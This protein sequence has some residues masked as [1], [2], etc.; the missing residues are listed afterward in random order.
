MEKIHARQEQAEIKEEKT[1]SQKITG[2]FE[3]LQ[4]KDVTLMANNLV[5]PDGFAK[6]LITGIILSGEELNIKVDS[7]F[8]KSHRKYYQSSQKFTGGENN[9]LSFTIGK[10]QRLYAGS[11]SIQEKHRPF[12]RGLGFTLPA[13]KLLSKTNVQ[14]GWGILSTKEAIEKLRDTPKFEPQFSKYEE[15]EKLSYEDYQKINWYPP[16]KDFLT[17][18]HLAR[19]AGM[20]DGGDQAEV[21]MNMM[22]N[23]FPRLRLEEVVILIPEKSRESI[24]RYLGKKLK[25]CEQ[26]S[27]K[28]KEAF[29]V[30]ISELTPE[31]V[32][33][34]YKNIYWYPQENIGAAIEYLSINPD[35]TKSILK[36]NYQLK[37]F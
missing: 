7:D 8:V 22:G 12:M 18:T 11:S 20:L 10:A 15:Y 4:S 26:F 25:E 30:E 23:E 36:S 35:L 24:K 19:K 34:K 5:R 29:G 27:K 6:T 1:E 14:P 31:K 13:E 37:H 33:E 16:K 21:N 2:Q 3:S 32:L 28:I 9:N 17:L